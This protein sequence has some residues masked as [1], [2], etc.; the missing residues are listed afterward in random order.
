MQG[1]LIKTVVNGIAL[2]AAA[3][4]ID[5]I[6]LGDDSELSTRLLTIAF[7]ALLF[8][9]VNAIVKPIAQLLSLPFIILTLGLFTLI[10]NAF[11]LQI[12]EWISGPLGL[13]FSIDAFFWDA[14][15][16]ALVITVVSMVVN[17]VVPDGK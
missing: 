15:L 2:W 11:M 13:D 1:F 12:T 9:V 4:A 10:V 8:G 6:H 14:V 17:L 3:A 16:G 7:V 5:G